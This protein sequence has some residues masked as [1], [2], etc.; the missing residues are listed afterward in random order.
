MKTSH[1]DTLLQ[2]VNTLYVQ[3]PDGFV[4]GDGT[5]TIYDP[6]VAEAIAA[7][8][9]P[10]QLVQ[11]SLRTLVFEKRG[12]RWHL[13][14]K[15]GP[16]LV[17]RLHRFASS[18]EAGRV[19]DLEDTGLIVRDRFGRDDWRDL[20]V[21]HDHQTLRFADRRLFDAL[22]SVF[23]GSCLA[24]EKQ[25]HIGQHAPIVF[26]DFGDVLAVLESVV[27]TGDATRHIYPVA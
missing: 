22:L 27:Y 2:S 15:R 19:L 23:P 6:R 12:K 14:R 1:V 20:V 3:R 11:Y 4:V 9:A 13:T 24:A 26:H 8:L 16:D 17:E 25:W 5:W 7:K 21:L 10:P 18:S